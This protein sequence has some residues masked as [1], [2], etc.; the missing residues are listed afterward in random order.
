MD[1]VG[2]CNL[3]SFD[4]HYNGHLS[5]GPQPTRP[6]CD[7][8][9]KNDPNPDPTMD[10]YHDPK[11]R[12][13]YDPEAD[14]DRAYD[15]KVD[16]TSKRKFIRKTDPRLHLRFRPADRAAGRPDCVD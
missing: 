12:Y 4:A 8:N 16:C 3:S 11:D 13:E 2:R 10:P 1:Q 14:P 6:F 15:P 5:S 7:Q 9:P